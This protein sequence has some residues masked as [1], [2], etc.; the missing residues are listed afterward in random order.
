MVGKRFGCG[1]SEMKSG[2]VNNKFALRWNVLLQQI[3]WNKPVDFQWNLFIHHGLTL[4]S[5]K[6]Q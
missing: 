1:E 3:Y 6:K 4:S 5:F 2:N